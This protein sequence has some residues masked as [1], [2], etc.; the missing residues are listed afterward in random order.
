MAAE[1]N[2]IDPQDFMS[3][4]YEGQDVNLL[5]SFDVNTFLSSSSYIELF[6]YDNNKNILTSNLNFTQ[7]TVQN[8]GQSAANGSNIS[9]IILDPEKILIDNGFDQGEYTTYFNF[10][11][12]QI[13]SDLESLYISEISSDRTELRLDSTA[14]TNLDI[15]EQTLKF[16]QERE[17]SPYFLDFYINFGENQLLIAN[18]IQLDN[19]DENNPTVLVKLYEP[20]PEEFGLNSTLWAVTVVEEPRAYQ[21][22]FEDIPII[23]I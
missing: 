15:V 14:L 7:Y 1:I 16:I 4:T 22:T 12:Q 3:Q 19:T 18:N 17:N 9:E 13:G 2:Q 8:N 6:I 23:I 20:L 21:V 5:T 10:F 11:N